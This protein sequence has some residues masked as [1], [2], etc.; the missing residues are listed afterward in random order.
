MPIFCIALSGITLFIC[1]LLSKP[2][3][4][5]SYDDFSI[6]TQDRSIAFDSVEMIKLTDSGLLSG[7]NCELSGQSQTLSL[8]LSHIDNYRNMLD[9]ITLNSETAK[10][11]N[12]TIIFGSVPEW[13]VA[14]EISIILTG[15]ARI[16]L[17][18]YA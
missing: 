1:R 5:A 6:C 2:R 8:P 14:L 9:F 11:K 13:I 18:A 12:K 7:W 16:V 3:I 4:V 17:Q 10:I 15:I